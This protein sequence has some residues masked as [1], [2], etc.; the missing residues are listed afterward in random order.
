MRSH[1]LSQIEYLLS[2]WVLSNKAV[3]TKF[4]EIGMIIKKAEW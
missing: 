3:L 4:R 2:G 1:I